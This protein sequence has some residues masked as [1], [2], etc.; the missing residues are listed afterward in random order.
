M[1]NRIDGDDTWQRG[2]AGKSL[3]YLSSPV[4][5]QASY[6]VVETCKSSFY[7]N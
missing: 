1:I 4:R 3:P 5:M 2:V 6:F 7:V